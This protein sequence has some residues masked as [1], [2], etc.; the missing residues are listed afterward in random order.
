MLT[1]RYIIKTNVINVNMKK[2]N[3]FLCY[4]T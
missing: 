2:I 4:S 1:S 3:L